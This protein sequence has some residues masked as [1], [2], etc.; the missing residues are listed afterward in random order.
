MIAIKCKFPWVARLLTGEPS[1]Y[2]YSFISLLEN[3]IL[4][5]SETNELSD[6]Q[7]QANGKP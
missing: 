1:R 2:M 6:Q 7:S 5:H 3:Q 4:M